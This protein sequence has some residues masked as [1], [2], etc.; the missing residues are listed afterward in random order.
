MVNTNSTELKEEWM[1][2][3]E[4]EN[5]QF[6]KRYDQIMQE[7]KEKEG[8]NERLNRLLFETEQ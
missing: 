6:R 8:E 4:S 3:L 2:R 1:Q 5:E 7:L